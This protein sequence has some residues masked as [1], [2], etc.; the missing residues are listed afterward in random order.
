LIG[1]EVRNRAQQQALARTGWPGDSHALASRQG[2]RGRF[3]DVC[4]QIANLEHRL[5][6]VMQASAVGQRH[7]RGRTARTAL[8]DWDII[9][10]DLVRPADM[11]L[12][13]ANTYWIVH[14]EATASSPKIGLLFPAAVAG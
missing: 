3:E 12:V 6:I 9:H 7:A 2:E 11:P 5:L 10:G 1:V 8:A 13:M 14:P 4:A